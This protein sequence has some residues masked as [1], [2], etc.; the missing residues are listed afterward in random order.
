MDCMIILFMY[1][2]YK[3]KKEG[4]RARGL[5]ISLRLTFFHLLRLDAEKEKRKRLI[6]KLLSPKQKN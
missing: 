4:R 1:V 3:V 5:F 6:E 2:R